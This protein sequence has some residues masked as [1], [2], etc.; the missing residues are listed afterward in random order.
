MQYGEGAREWFAAFVDESAG[1]P[2]RPSKQDADDW[3]KAKRW[4]KFT[5]VRFQKIRVLKVAAARV[6]GGVQ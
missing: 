1:L 4:G 5:A 6:C 3:S 2:D